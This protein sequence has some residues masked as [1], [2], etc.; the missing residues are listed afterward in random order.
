[1]SKPSNKIWGAIWG[2]ACVGILFYAGYYALMG[3]NYCY[4]NAFVTTH[5]YRV[6]SAIIDAILSGSCVLFEM[7]PTDILKTI[8]G[9][10]SLLGWSWLF[11]VLA[12]YTWTDS[13]KEK[14][15]EQLEKEKTDNEMDKDSPKIHEMALKMMEENKASEKREAPKVK[16]PKNP[17]FK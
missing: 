3:K 10:M 7:L 11:Y 2:A 8:V 17:F 13:A 6:S 12:K 9:T 5:H 1:M 16:S 15:E 4:L 14:S